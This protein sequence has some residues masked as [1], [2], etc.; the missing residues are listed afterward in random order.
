MFQKVSKSS[1]GKPYITKLLSVLLSPKVLLN[2]GIITEIA[3]FPL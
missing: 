1:A 3:G 2:T